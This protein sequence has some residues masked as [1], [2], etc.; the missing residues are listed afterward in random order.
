MTL[1]V[2]DDFRDFVAARW[3]DLEGVAFVVTLDAATARRVTTD[4]LAVLHQQWREA[5]DEGR[6]V[7]MARRAVL[8]AAVAATPARAVPRP[9]GEP[10]DARRTAGGALAP[11][12][13][14]SPGVP[15]DPWADPDDDDPVH[16]AL[17]AVVRGGSPLERA[18]VAAGSV[19]GA[20][21]DEVADL[22]GMPAAD[23]RDRAAA[24][25]GR[26]THVHDAARAAEGLE[27]ADWALDVD[28]D[29]VVER[30]LA[31]QGDPPDPAALVEDRRRS[32][33]RRS[34]V[35]GGAAVVAAGAL[36]WWVVG[37]RPAAAGVASGAG[38][39]PTGT[40]AP[41]DPSW[42]NV[43]RWAARGR[44]AT[45]PRVQG[46]VV[47]RSEGVARLLF[48]DDVEGRRLVVSATLNPGTQDVILQAWQGAAGEDPAT[49]QEVL[50][51]NPFVAAGQ[52][53][54]PVA[55]S[56]DPGTLLLLLARPPTR[57]G[58]YSTIVTPTPDGSIDRSWAMVRLAA[59]IGVTGWEGEQG[60]ALRVRCGGFDGPPAGS[61]Q[62]YV[63]QSGLDALAGFAE[64]T[65]RF[66]AA[67]LGRPV[68][69]VSSEVVTDAKVGGG[70][71]DPI[72]F[73]A[74]G[75]D[76]RVRVLRTTTSDG[77]VVRSVR[78]VD[79]GRS[80]VNWLDLEQP[81]VLPADTPL[82]EPVVLRLEDSR[83]RVGRF[84]V[85]APGAARVQLLSTSPNAYPV[86]KVTTTRPGGVAVVEVVNAD[87]AAG[88]RL[89]RRDAA[90]RRLGTGVPR[91]SRDLLDLWPAEP[92]SY[93]S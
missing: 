87:D 25:R 18:L 80:K 74:Q 3:P 4:A 63:N 10:G 50:L 60:P 16:A 91:V 32:V 27:P 12:A 54:V 29:A 47:A 88:F 72:A 55:V 6:P 22:L 84:L 35:T 93:V 68:D 48:A 17:E 92:R 34:L 90:G 83:P 36:G 85:I 20:G 58:M 73:S 28:L 57:F 86:S 13:V 49:L 46:L 23:V 14:T 77:I 81:S 7:A 24:L 75:G 8:A 39:G 21:A 62:T 67:A 1:T 70:V 69:S 15:P 11:D 61:L 26:L 42:Q 41:N 66:V 56:N 38:A 30:L 19:W 9:A 79:D 31:G 89:V 40:P 52:E 5:L 43:S 76:G 53:C 59:G 37:R 2:E 78:V 44:L 65:R 82:D 45:D 71:I 51:Q 64:E 33:R